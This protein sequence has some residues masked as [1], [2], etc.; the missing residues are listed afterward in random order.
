MLFAQEAILIML[1]A[2][3]VPSR[4]ESRNV[5]ATEWCAKALERH[6]RKTQPVAIGSVPFL[7]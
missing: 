2:M 7:V 4:M 6:H 1:I 5:K 3:E